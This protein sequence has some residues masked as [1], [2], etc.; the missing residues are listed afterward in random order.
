MEGVEWN[1]PN[2]SFQ[3]ERHGGTVNG[4]SRAEMQH[5]EIDVVKETRSLVRTGY[6]QLKAMAESW[7][8]RPI[9]KDLASHIRSGLDHEGLRWR[10]SGKV[11]I[12]R[13]I[14][15]FCAR[16]TGH[17][18]AKR[19]NAAISDFLCDREWRDKTWRT[20]CQEDASGPT[21]KHR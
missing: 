10:K 19:L 3:I 13:E 7:N 11:T 1:P 18:R 8:A 4:S 5:W 17:S 2:L 16:E 9:A 15:P 21:P 20:P 12:N 14:I 6:R